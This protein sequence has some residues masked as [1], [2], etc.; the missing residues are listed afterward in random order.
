MVLLVKEVGED[1]LS[2]LNSFPIKFESYGKGNVINVTLSCQLTKMAMR[3]HIA[4]VKLSSNGTGSSKK[5][6][7]R[8]QNSVLIY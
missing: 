3:E 6:A 1:V 8:Y 7:N 4:G 2:T 5:G